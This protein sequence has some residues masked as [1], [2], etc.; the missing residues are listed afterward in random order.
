[1][2]RLSRPARIIVRVVKAP[3]QQ[4]G[5]IVIVLPESRQFDRSAVMAYSVAL[6]TFFV[7]DLRRLMDRTR[8]ADPH[9]AIEQ[10]VAFEYVYGE[11]VRLAT[12]ANVYGDRTGADE[13][14][15]NDDGDDT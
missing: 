12:K 10:R 5:E 11:P 6:Q 15:A 13:P 7:E 2:S 1:M 14:P 8:A 4:R 3:V 9:T